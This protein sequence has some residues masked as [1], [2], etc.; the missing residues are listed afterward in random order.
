MSKLIELCCLCV[1]LPL[2]FSAFSNCD[3]DVPALLLLLLLVAE[4][5]Q[6]VCIVCCQMWELAGI[7]GLPSCTGA[8]HAALHASLPSTS[9]QATSQ[10]HQAILPI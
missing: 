3:T 5:A 10:Q 2:Q 6:S 1:L 7:L 9:R 4:H 8:P